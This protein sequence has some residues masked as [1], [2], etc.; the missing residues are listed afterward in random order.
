[1]YVQC[2]LFGFLCF[3]LRM[4]DCVCVCVYVLIHI[5]FDLA[6]R[7][8][9]ACNRLTTLQWALAA[10]L[11]VELSLRALGPTVRRTRSSHA[12]SLANHFERF[13]KSQSKC[14]LSSAAT[15]NWTSTQCQCVCVCTCV[16]ACA[17]ITLCVLGPVCVRA[18]VYIKWA[19]LMIF[20]ARLCP[21]SFVCVCVCA[22]WEGRA[23]H[24]Q[25]PI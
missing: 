12:K 22:A 7:L 23:T 21:G 11:E 24:R 10:S 13:L 25:W 15:S 9:E 3:F 18:C 16:C 2:T 5:L 20:C 19:H 4:C 6:A 8:T 1:M 14:K 17:S